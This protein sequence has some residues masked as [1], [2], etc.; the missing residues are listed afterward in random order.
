M[1]EAE[2]VFTDLVEKAQLAPSGEEILIQ[3]LKL[4]DM[5]IA[6]NTA[7]GD[8]ALNPVRVFS[9]ATPEEQILVRLDDKVSR[10]VRG[11]EAGEDVLLDMAGYWCMLQI[12]RDRHEFLEDCHEGSA[13]GITDQDLN[14]IGF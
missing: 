11:D 14:E 2:T 4:A 12:C 7:Y 8:S 6:K 10:L 1:L 3:C 5:L 13:G 9:K